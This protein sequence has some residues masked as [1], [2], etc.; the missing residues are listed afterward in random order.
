M[1]RVPIPKPMI[2]QAKEKKRARS[3]EYFRGRS[4][5]GEDMVVSIS[6]HNLKA[7]CLLSSYRKLGRSGPLRLLWD[8]ELHVNGLHCYA[9]RE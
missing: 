4:T 1:D 5:S 6:K 9:Y 2:P 3:R 8:I 7:Q